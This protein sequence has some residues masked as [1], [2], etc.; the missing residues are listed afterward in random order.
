VLTEKDFNDILRA[1]SDFKRLSNHALHVESV[2]LV[3]E[4]SKREQVVEVVVVVRGSLDNGVLSNLNYFT[5][6]ASAV[7]ETCVVGNLLAELPVCLQIVF[8][9]VRLHFLVALV[10]STLLE[11]ERFLLS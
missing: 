2:V 4:N 9:N 11:L 8:V 7:F 5:L 6:H 1:V 3:D 10:A